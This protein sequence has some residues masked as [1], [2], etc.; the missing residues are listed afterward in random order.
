MV[1]LREYLPC[2]SSY[3]SAW[4][5]TIHLCCKLHNSRLNKHL[6]LHFFPSI[7]YSIF[8]IVSKMD[9]GIIQVIIFVVIQ[10][11]IALKLRVFFH[12]KN[13]K[14]QPKN[15]S[16]SSEKHL[17]PRWFSF[18]ACVITQHAC[19]HQALKVKSFKHS[20]NSKPMPQQIQCVNLNNILFTNKLK[21]LI[22]KK[23]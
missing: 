2:V 13:I 1:L 21:R 19:K 11:K 6:E 9:S 4:W 20:R 7:M 8:P 3:G 22:R 12:D 10:R 15:F 17:T 16:M 5:C 14:R 18:G 23:Q